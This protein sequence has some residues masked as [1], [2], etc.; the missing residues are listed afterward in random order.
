MA[1]RT[2]EILH[3]INL[4][5]TD[6]LWR[7]ETQTK[8]EPAVLQNITVKYYTDLA[9]QT[10]TLASP[11]GK[12]IAPQA[13]SFTVEQDGQGRYLTFTLPSLQYWNMIFMR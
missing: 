4:T 13:L 12:S 11:D 7:D 1:D 2:Y 8:A 6:N 5:G 9:P 10:V 3:L